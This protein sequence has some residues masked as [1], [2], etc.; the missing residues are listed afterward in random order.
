MVFH[1]NIMN[2]VLVARNDSDAMFARLDGDGSIYDYV[3][4][5][6]VTFD[7]SDVTWGWGHY[8]MSYETALKLIQANN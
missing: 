1:N 3:V 4:G 7:G 6:K 2:L 5:R 8:N